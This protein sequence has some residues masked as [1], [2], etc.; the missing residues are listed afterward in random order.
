MASV[1][2]PSDLAARIRR[3][4]ERSV[5]RAKNGIKFVAGIGEPVVGQTPKD[6]VWKR[7]KVELWRFHSDDRQ[8]RPPLLLVMSLVSRSYIFD[9]RPGNSVVEYFLKNGIDVFGLDWG[10]PD[11]LEAGNTLETYCDE[12]LPR[13]VEA[14][15]AEAGTSDVNV[16]G[17]C[18][19]G[20]L[21]VI[22]AAAH[23]E[24]PIRSLVSVATP[25]DSSKAQ[26][27]APVLDAGRMEPEELFDETGNVPAD[28]IATGFRTARP[29]ANITA[30]V[31]LW[32]NLWNDEFVEGYQTMDHWA[33]DQ[34]P[35][36][37]ATF[38]QTTRMLSR[39]NRLAKN[40][41]R[42]GGRK[43]DLKDITCPFLN[44]IAEK[45]H[46]APVESAAPLTSAVG[47][48]ES[49]ELRL[50]AGHV[51]LFVGRSAQ[52]ITLPRVTEWI[53]RHSE[54]IEPARSESA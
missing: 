27:F 7:D 4:V 37:G 26:A 52:K 14:V 15:C 11:E 38:A 36:P 42:L 28:V 18:F 46:L 39:E 33:R 45:D 50:N 19:G 8:Y 40:T 22:Y 21:S 13:A 47:S 31:N 32:E 20:I 44:V 3:D 16:L 29:M 1:F 43:I 24:A 12:Y 6:V 34:I 49:E 51:G 30:Y 48:R 17:Y 35:F 9:L 41:M 23:P 54:R 10:I 53:Q 2:S 25:F 5:L